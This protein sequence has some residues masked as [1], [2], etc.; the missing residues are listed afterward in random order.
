MLV[1]ITQ[2]YSIFTFLKSN[3]VLKVLFTLSPVIKDLEHSFT[4]ERETE[5]PQISVK[6]VVFSISIKY[7]MIIGTGQVNK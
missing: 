6:K 2:K 3:T 7:F 1:Y 5:V 4:S